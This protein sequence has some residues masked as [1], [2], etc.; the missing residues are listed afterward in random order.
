MAAQEG[1]ALPKAGTWIPWAEYPE[2]GDTGGAPFLT[3]EHGFL[4]CKPKGYARWLSKCLPSLTHRDSAP[5]AFF[6]ESLAEPLWEARGKQRA[7]KSKDEIFS[8]ME[9]FV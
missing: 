4:I 6:W 2:G 8:S 9:N 7:G 3:P 5:G 1:G